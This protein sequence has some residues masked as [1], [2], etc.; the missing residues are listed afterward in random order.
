MV[1]IAMAQENWSCF[2]TK[3]LNHQLTQ[4]PRGVN[5]QS[6]QGVIRIENDSETAGHLLAMTS[7]DD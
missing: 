2:V 5:R 4:G 7:H 6:S 1:F 3:L